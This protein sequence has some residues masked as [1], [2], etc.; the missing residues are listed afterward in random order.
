MPLLRNGRVSDEDRWRRLG[1]EEPLPAAAGAEA[2]P[3]ALSLPRFLEH[4]AAATGT[5]QAGLGRVGGV[6]LAP[7]DDAL[8]LAPHLSRLQLIAI[9]FPAYTDGRGYSQARQLRRRLGFE[10]E[11]RAFGDVR[12]DQVLFMMRSG[13]DAFEFG[14][15]PDLPSLRQAVARYRTSYQPSY[16]LP[17]A[18]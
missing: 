18:G 10:G 6:W 9:D 3:V 8:A 16:A 1:D 2:S 13:I 15:S 14:D 5:E 7:T 4:V 11:I 17:I 12:P